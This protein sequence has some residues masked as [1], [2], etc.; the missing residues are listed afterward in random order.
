MRALDF[1]E[2]KPPSPIIHCDLRPGN[3]LVGEDHVTI[4][5]ADWGL[6]CSTSDKESIKRDYIQTRWY[7]APEIIMRLPYDSAVDVWSAGCILAELLT[8]HPLFK[9]NNELEHILM[10]KHLLGEPPREFFVK[11][12]AAYGEGRGCMIPPLSFTRRTFN[13][14]KR[15][16]KYRNTISEDRWELAK[17]ADLA[18]KMLE[19]NPRDRITVQEALKHPCLEGAA[20]TLEKKVS[21][22]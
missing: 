3:I 13:I 19:W 21:F 2:R 10:L 5:V 12:S 9:S 8:N 16:C 20:E 7:R 18:T 15:I 4:K 17:F 22:I 1:A 6:A 11:K 14:A